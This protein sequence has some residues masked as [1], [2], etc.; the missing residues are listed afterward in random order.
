MNDSTNVKS[1]N[2]QQNVDEQVNGASSGQ[3]DGNWWQENGQNDE[4]NLID[5]HV[6]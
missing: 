3:Q 2:E 1:E 5:I 6:V 4:Q